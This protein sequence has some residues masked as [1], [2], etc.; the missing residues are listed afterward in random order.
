LVLKQL[1]AWRGKM[2]L[3]RE[4]RLANIESA[5]MQMMGLLH[6]D[7]YVKVRFERDVDFH[8]IL[9]TTWAELESFGWIED[10]STQDKRMH[11]LTRAGWIEGLKRTGKLDSEKLIG[12]K[13][14]FK[15][16]VKGR[17]EDGW[18]PLSRCTKETGL[19]ERW[20]VSVIESGLLGEMFSDEIMD[21]GWWP[22]GQRSVIRVS[23]RFGM[24][25]L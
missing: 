6:E 17:T 1:L 24:E 18:L 5:L 2:P 19:S 23:T 8:D 12:L 3:S 14:L 9:G 20:I 15:S 13:G 10:C 25:K 16:C 22:S 21:V 7:G 11:E 4:K